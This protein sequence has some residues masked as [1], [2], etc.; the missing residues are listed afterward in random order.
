MKKQI[1]LGL[2]ILILFVAGFFVYQYISV[3]PDCC[4]KG[5]SNGVNK[6]NFE[7]EYAYNGDSKWSYSIV[8]MLPNPCYEAKV[9]G[10][11]KESYPEQVSIILT[12][13]QPSSDTM[14]S[15]VIQDYSYDGEFS[16][17]EKAIVEFE[18]KLVK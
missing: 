11:V 2:S 9:E 13:T 17:S 5:I 18:V 6:D 1:I 14:C 12:I 15:E 7:F 16:A 3:N 10:L 4:S 8:G